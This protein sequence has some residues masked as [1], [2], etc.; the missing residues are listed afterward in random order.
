[1][2]RVVK[3]RLAAVVALEGWAKAE[4]WLAEHHPDETLATYRERIRTEF[5]DEARASMIS[6]GVALAG[7]IVVIA[8][9]YL[10][11]KGLQ[12]ISGTMS[13][14][15]VLLIIGLIALGILGAWQAHL[16]ARLLAGGN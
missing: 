15:M 8:S 1:M 14:V 2:D 12:P 13:T 7:P 10:F 9:Y 5:G 4:A 11:A 3:D 6:A 16:R